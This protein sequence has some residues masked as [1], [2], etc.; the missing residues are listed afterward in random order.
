DSGNARVR[1][2]AEASATSYGQAM[3]AGD[4]YTVMGNGYTEYSGDGGLATSAQLDSP[5]DVAVDANDDVAVADSANYRVRLIAASTGALYGR[6]MTAGHIYTVSGNGTE[7]QQ[8]GCNG[9]AATTQ[10]EGS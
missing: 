6:Q 5:T 2:V 10:P 4:V 8:P 3:T 7:P 9:K 1:V